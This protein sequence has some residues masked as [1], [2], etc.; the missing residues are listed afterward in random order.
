MP[1]AQI[2][3]LKLHFVERGSRPES[4][5][6]VHGNASSAEYW[7]KFLNILPPRCGDRKISSSE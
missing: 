2:E 7:D 5:L 3:G 6:L 1:Y 4:L